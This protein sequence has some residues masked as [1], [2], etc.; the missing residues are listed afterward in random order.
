MDICLAGVDYIQQHPEQFIESIS[1]ES[2]MQY[3]SNMSTQG[4]WCYGII[5]QAVANALNCKID[6][7]ESADNFANINVIHPI[8]PNKMPTAIC[9]GHLA[10]FHYVSTAK[11]A[12]LTTLIMLCMH[13]LGNTS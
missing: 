6:I 11:K 8:N 4:T 5:V 7:A 12:L 3:M 10:D 9:I 2:W 13:I 1:D